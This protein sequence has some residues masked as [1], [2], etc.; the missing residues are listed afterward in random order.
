M[1]LWK[2]P[3]W[4][5]IL[6]LQIWIY[7][8]MSLLLFSRPLPCRGVRFPSVA[9]ERLVAQGG[10]VG[11]FLSLEVLGE[12]KVTT[13]TVLPLLTVRLRHICIINLFS[14][15][16]YTVVRYQGRLD[17][18]KDFFTIDYYFATLLRILE[19]LSIIIRYIDDVFVL[20]MLRYEWRIISH[21]FNVLI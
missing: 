12:Y 15:W 17:R 5:R 18:P 9:K 11:L 6:Y 7:E 2:C 8:K 20:T 13:N 3:W 1:F 16:T 19:L 10:A 4:S 21:F 14:K